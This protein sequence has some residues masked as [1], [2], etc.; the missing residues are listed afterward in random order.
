MRFKQQEIL[1][2]STCT[3]DRRGG[4]RTGGFMRSSE[5]AAWIQQVIGVAPGSCV[6]NKE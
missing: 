6:R 1:P 5:H 2:T 3:M 4:T